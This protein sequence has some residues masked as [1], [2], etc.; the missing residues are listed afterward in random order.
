MKRIL[1]TG[2]NSYVGTSFENY[3]KQWPDQYQVD[4]ISLHGD[5]WYEK[6]F[7]EYDSI[8]HVAGIAHS[9]IRRASHK[10]KSKYYHINTNLTIEV[11]KKAKADGAKQFIFMSS[12][13][14]YGDSAPNGKKKV[15]T[16][17]TVPCPSNF[18][19]DSKL[20]AENGILLLNDESFHIVIIRAPL[21][22]GKGSKGNYVLLS[23]F[24]QKF[25]IF[26]Y[27]E[28]ERSMLYIENLCEFLKVMIDYEKSGL[29]FP[30]N[31]EYIKTSVLVK[32]IA[33]IYGK[34]IWMTRLFNP[35]IRLMF[36]TRTVNK[37]FGNLV[38]E[39]FLSN[40]DKVN[41]Q[42]RSFR[43]SVEFTELENRS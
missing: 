24:V 31:K 27:V 39:Q 15:I 32:T 42:I 16:R 11:A 26:P 1:I 36:G 41:Y 21:I 29:F 13:I 28:N 34:K 23:K 38:Y 37:I 8:L 30:Q 6:N 18:Y 35:A 19:G 9:D 2:A 17:D 40:Y 4:T 33:E 25:P 20:Q 22:Y 14:V 43:E 7:G 5:A 3:V 10:A 12:I